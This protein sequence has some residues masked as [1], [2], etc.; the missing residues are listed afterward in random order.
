MKSPGFST[1][2]GQNKT[3]AG[4]AFTLI[5]LIGVL[6]VIAI[7][8][9]TL[10]P[11]LIRQM[12]KLAGDQESATLNKLGDAFEQSIM[13]TRYIPSHNSATNWYNAIA[14]ELGVNVSN[15]LTNSR[16]NPR[17]FV[18]DPAL[19]IG[20]NV[21]GQAYR[22]TTVGTTNFPTLPRM[23]IVSSISQ[24]MPSMTSGVLSSNDFNAIWNWNDTSA[25]PPGASVLAG[26]T[27]GE[28]LRVYRINLSDLFV[29][30]LLTAYQSTDLP[31]YSIDSTIG[32]TATKVLTNSIMDSFFIRGSALTLYGYQTNIDSQQILLRDYSF[33]YNLDVW[34]GSL[35]G[36]L[37]VAGLDLASVVDRYLSCY[38]N[39]NATF[40]STQQVVVVAKMKAYLDNYSLWADS[41]FLNTSLKN[42][43]KDTDQPDMVT[44]VQQQY[45]ATAN[46]PPEIPCSP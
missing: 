2:R 14:T 4:N 1:T 32:A 9:A 15:V 43:L 10:T 22:Q 25:S 35:A 18:I 36:A 13:R 31:L 29:R 30:L 38:P 45:Q 21:A 23:M 7:L 42:Q 26:F 46:T 3:R 12:D 33:V 37:V 11:A 19:K 28:D 20:T 27:R 24:K 41:L 44:A 39:P 16:R 8:A 34:R 40:G 6:T 17:F 5:E